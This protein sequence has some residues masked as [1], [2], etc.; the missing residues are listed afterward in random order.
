MLLLF[1]IYW[2]PTAKSS[3]RGILRNYTLYPAGW[4]FKQ[5]RQHKKHWEEG[6]RAHLRKV[7]GKDSSGLPGVLGFFQLLCSHRHQ[8]ALGCAHA[9]H[10]HALRIS[11]SEQALQRQVELFGAAGA[12]IADIGFPRNTFCIDK[13][14]DPKNKFNSRQVQIWLPQI[15]A[16]HPTS[17]KS[18]WIE[19]NHKN[20]G[21]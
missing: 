13:C 5:D 2:I 16:Q 7:A 6:T 15:M 17:L 20:E 12:W 9:R 19:S 10:H 3:L 21:V 8:H 1:N 18:V 14:Q 11:H 4:Q